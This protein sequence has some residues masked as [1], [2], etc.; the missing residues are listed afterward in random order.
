MK[1][2]LFP[3]LCILLLLVSCSE[4]IESIG[5]WSE[6][7]AVIYSTKDEGGKIV[8]EKELMTALLKD[9]EENIEDLFGG[10]EMYRLTSSEWKQR[11]IVLS[12]LLSVTGEE[13]VE[14]AYESENKLLRKSQWK[15]NMEQISN[16][17]DQRLLEYVK[18][19]GGDYYLYSAEN[20]LKDIPVEGNEEK[21]RV[22]LKK[23]IK[24]IVG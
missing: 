21:I 16:G 1:K 22:F 18:K 9:G 8:I 24:A 2:L 13:S 23:W 3:L 7:G 5:V 11:D 17:Y 6:E 4:K 14:K 15:E 12:S 10:V 19:N 20:V